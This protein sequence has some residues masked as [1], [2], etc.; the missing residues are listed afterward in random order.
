MIVVKT[1]TRDVEKNSIRWFAAVWIL[2][3]WSDGND[4]PNPDHETK[5]R[6]RRQVL[7]CLIDRDVV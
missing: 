3:L 2:H 4:L 6:L 7:A 5:T 1:G